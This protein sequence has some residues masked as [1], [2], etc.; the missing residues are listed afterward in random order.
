M[1]IIYIYIIYII[2]IK[3]YIMYI[4]YINYIYNIYNYIIIHCP[5]TAQHQTRKQVFNT[6]CKWF[7]SQ[8]EK[9]R[10][11][12]HML[13]ALRKQ[14]FPKSIGSHNC[15]PCLHKTITKIPFYFSFCV[16][17]KKKWNFLII[18]SSVPVTLGSEEC[19]FIGL[20]NFW[21]S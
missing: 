19:I 5:L 2:Y 8:K 16:F 4:I 21:D 17:T 10:C 9:K 18:S 14:Y 3:L 20:S 15:L 6:S 11:R 7:L 1:Y 12:S 13:F